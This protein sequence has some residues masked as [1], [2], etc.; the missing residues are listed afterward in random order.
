MADNPYKPRVVKL[1]YKSTLTI[2]K[3]KSKSKSKKIN[4]H[5]LITFH[6]HSI[7]F[8]TNHYQSLPFI[9]INYHSLPFITIH[10]HSLPFITMTIG[11]AQARECE[12]VGLRKRGTM[13][14]RNRGTAK[15]RDCET[16][17]LSC[18]SMRKR[19]GLLAAPQQPS[20]SVLATY[21]CCD[22]LT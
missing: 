12:S 14:V 22:L 4:N 7:P 8:I 11:T 10:Y 6:Y 15:A 19:E 2:S 5:Y 17:G 9:T 1:R 3:S 18:A 13:G 20:G 16:E 21:Y